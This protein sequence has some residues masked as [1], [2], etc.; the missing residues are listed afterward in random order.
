MTNPIGTA[1]TNDL[2]AHPKILSFL[3]IW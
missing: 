2:V 3:C 1:A